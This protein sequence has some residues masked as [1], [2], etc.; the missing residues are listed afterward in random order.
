MVSWV[1]N[2][3]CR[4]VAQDSGDPGD[5]MRWQDTRGVELIYAGGPCHAPTCI[6]MEL[7]RARDAEIANIALSLFAGALVRP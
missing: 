4:T 5:Y 7:Q 6:S 3:D 2:H 1:E